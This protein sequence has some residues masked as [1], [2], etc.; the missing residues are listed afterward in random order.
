MAFVG[1]AVIVIGTLMSDSNDATPIG[2]ELGDAFVRFDR[3]VEYG[4]DGYAE[5]EACPVGDPRGLAE[6]LTSV[7]SIDQS[8]LDGV[9]LVEAYERD[10]DYP[11]ITQCFVT[12]DP[13]DRAGPTTIGFS[14]SG[15][16]AG[17]YLDFLQD[18][19]Y[20]VDI[21]VSVDVRRRRDGER[22]SG[23]LFGYC[24]RGVDLS[25]CGADVVDR[26][27]GVVLSVYLQ[28][29]SRTADEVVAALESIVNE[30]AENL[31]LENNALGEG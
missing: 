2:P 15:V 30:M 14:V 13:E 22:V 26:A 10:S 17:P 25:G 29:R 16:P 12:S 8:V 24:Y 18:S 28:G 31:L 23:D 11:A 9:T 4:V 5:L 20:D 27:N 19:A 7:V 1:T 3:S 6:S 21:D